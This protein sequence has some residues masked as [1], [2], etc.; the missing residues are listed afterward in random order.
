MTQDPEFHV[1]EV[2]KLNAPQKFENIPE[3]FKK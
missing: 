2:L 3:S 1:S